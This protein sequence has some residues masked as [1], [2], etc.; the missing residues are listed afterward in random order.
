MS[1]RVSTP[2][3][4]ANCRNYVVYR[5]SVITS[6]DPITPAWAQTKRKEG[7]EYHRKEENSALLSYYAASSGNFLPWALKIE[8]IGCPETSV[9]NYRYSLRN[10]P[11]ERS[12]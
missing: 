5:L 7:A 2:A 10:K 1:G 9:R 6:S 8:M 4:C 12:S 11:E 3:I